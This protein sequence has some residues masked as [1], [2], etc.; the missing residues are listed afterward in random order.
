VASIR[1]GDFENEENLGS[2]SKCANIRL[3]FQVKSRITEGS[4]IKKERK[5]HRHGDRYKTKKTA[6]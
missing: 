6:L 3:E 5:I 2:V 4:D 1:T